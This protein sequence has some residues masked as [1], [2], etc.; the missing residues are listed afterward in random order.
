MEIS[1]I[2]VDTY[3]QVL[4]AHDEASGLKAIIAL[5]NTNCGPAVGGTRLYPYPTEEDALQDVLRLSKGMTYKSALANVPFGGGKSVI[6]GDV[7]DKSE[8]L[9]KAFGHFVDTLKGAYICAE[10][11]NTTPQDMAI[12]RR[13]TPHVLGLDGAS[14]DPSP[15]TALGVIESMRTTV[16]HLGLDMENLTVTIQGVGHVGKIITEML[17][18]EDVTVYISDI[19]EDVLRDVADKTGAIVV[20]PEEAL[21]TP[22]DILAPSA[23]GAVLNSQTIPHLQCKAIVG[24]ANNQLETFEDAA[25]LHQRGVLYAPDYLVNAGGIINVFFEHQSETY[26]AQ[27]ARRKV[28]EIGQTLDTIFKLAEKEN[29]LPI[30]AADRLAEERFTQDTTANDQGGTHSKVS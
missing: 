12:V 6:I 29:I 28:V 4:K 7:H 24:A 23:M 3:H 14:G 11:I 26:D 2:S 8:A 10:D 9:L 16:N 13:A 27:G 15:L 22:C 18:E 25:R 30:Q 5:H 21:T 19:R 20:A 1:E 17:R